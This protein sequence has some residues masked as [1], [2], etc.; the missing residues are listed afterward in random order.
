MRSAGPAPIAFEG[1]FAEWEDARVRAGGYDQASILEAV[2]NATLRVA[3]GEAVYERDSVLF[4]HVERSWPILAGLLWA[5]ARNEGRLRVLDFGGSLG[6]SY[7]QNKQFLDDLPDVRWGIVEQPDYVA[8][9]REHFAN[10][11]LHFFETVESCAAALRPNVALL[12]SVLQYVRHYEGV[13]ERIVAARP[14][15]IV[16]DRTIVN[17]KRRDTVHIQTVPRSIYSASYPCRSIS[18]E[19]LLRIF[20]RSGY[21]LVSEFDDPPFPALDAI[22]SLFKG[23]LFTLEASR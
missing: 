9:G 6:T 7:R 14:G 23:Y 17:R 16:V 21:K 12:S 11:T 20:A 15:V 18:E 13:V 4:D 8:V 2:K 1:E 5:A 19:T 3:S 10:E 22:E